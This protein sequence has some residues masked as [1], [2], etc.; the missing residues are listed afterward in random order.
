[1]TMPVPSAS[2]SGTSRRGS[3]TSP[4]VKVMLFQASEVKSEPICATRAR[5]AAQRSTSPSSP[6][7]MR[8]RRAEP[9]IPEVR[10]DGQGIP[11]KRQSE[12]NQREQRSG[13]GGGEDVLDQ[14]AVVQPARVRPRQERDDRDP[15]ELRDRERERVAGEEVDRRDQ[16]AVL[17]NAREE[18]AEITREADATAAIG[19]GLDAGKSV[20]P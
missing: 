19:A 18:H 13:L 14:P 15:H 20:Q 10:R 17:G 6:G 8:D 7:A 5:Q 4:A 3:F 1:M 9:G 11:A 2:E 16:V 12:D